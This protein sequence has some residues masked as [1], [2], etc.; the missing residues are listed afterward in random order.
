MVR[1]AEMKHK[2][3]LL[4]LLTATINYFTTKAKS[5]GD[6]RRQWIDKDEKLHYLHLK[7]DGREIRDREITRLA[8][9]IKAFFGRKRGTKLG[10]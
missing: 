2:M 4:N 1:I 5:S 3:K 10:M 6:H 9:R 7:P 8:Q